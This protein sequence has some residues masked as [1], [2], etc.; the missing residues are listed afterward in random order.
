M[1]DVI[2]KKSFIQDKGVFANRDFKR[3]EIVIEWKAC[4]KV[5]TPK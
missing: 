3:G 4:S 5:L 1:S 2:V